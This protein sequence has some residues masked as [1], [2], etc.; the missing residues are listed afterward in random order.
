MSVGTKAKLIFEQ[1]KL[2]IFLFYFHLE[3]GKDFFDFLFYLILIVS[4]VERKKFFYFFYFLFF[5]KKT[6]ME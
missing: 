6:D 5:I 3:L 1:T 4:L 2:L